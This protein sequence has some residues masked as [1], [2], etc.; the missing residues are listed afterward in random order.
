MNH[1][2]AVIG[3]GY[4]G[5]VHLEALK[6]IGLDIAAVSDT[7]TASCARS[8]QKFGI[9]QSYGD[10]R[11]LLDQADIDAVHICTPNHLHYEIAMEALKRGLHVYCEKPLALCAAEAETL[12]EAAERAGVI[13]GVNFNYRYYPAVQHARGMVQNGEVGKVYIITGGYLQDWLLY[14]TDYNWRLEP[15]IGGVSRAMADIGAHWCDLAQH[16]T[17]LRITEVMA[18]LM[19]V[20]T[21]RKKPLA[22]AQTFQK[23]AQGTYEERPM[24]TEDYGGVLVRFE[25]G[26][27]GVFCVSQVS[28]GQKCRIR[29]EVY[30]S[31]E[32][33]SWDHEQANSLWVGSRDE[34]CRIVEKGVPVMNAEGARFA[35]YPAG[36]PE[37]YPDVVKNAC[38][39]F[40]ACIDT[41]FSQTLPTF[42]DGLNACRIVE[43]VLKSDKEKRWVSI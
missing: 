23:A 4:I 43:A 40:Y 13:A 10:Y 31:K 36:H 8:A 14:D 17:G 1:K 18:D 6:R 5:N 21:V 9:G 37:G 11:Q 7:D 24:D 39:D 26:A 19:T 35:H 34:G 27:K 20:H 28:A 2:I 32:S 16:V 15:E 33:V 41:G 29:L 38:I 30:G 42:R 25:N 12:A 22:A 3:M